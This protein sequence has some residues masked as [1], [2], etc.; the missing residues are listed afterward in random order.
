MLYLGIALLCIAASLS[1][2]FG[3]KWYKAEKSEKENRLRQDQLQ[4]QLHSSEKELKKVRSSNR[5][6]NI[7]YAYRKIP[8]FKDSEKEQRRVEENERE[9][10]ALENQISTID[11]KMER[12]RL[13][14]FV[15]K[16]LKAHLTHFKNSK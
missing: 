9:E 2:I 7:K 14:H 12:I 3:F 6:E 15:I 4:S 10:N 1:A 16:L 5:R 13:F 8:F 11:N